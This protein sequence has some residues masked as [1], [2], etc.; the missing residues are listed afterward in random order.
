MRVRPPLEQLQRFLTQLAGS[1][2]RRRQR[3]LLPE[4][5]NRL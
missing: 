1:G 4:P 3:A 2:R 5:Q